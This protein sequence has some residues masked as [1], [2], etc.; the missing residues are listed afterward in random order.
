[1][2]FNIYKRGQGKYTRLCTAFGGALIAGGG[3]WR[4]YQMLGAWLADPL[5]V[6]IERFVELNHI[7]PENLP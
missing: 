2:G 1:M 3:C 5:A 4:L 7:E 6:G